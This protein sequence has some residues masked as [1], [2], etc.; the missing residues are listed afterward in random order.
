MTDAFTPQPIPTS[1]LVLGFLG[2]AMFSCRFLIQWIA[3][4]R[5]KTSI[6]PALFWWFS[7]AGGSFLLVYALLRRDVV[8]VVGQAG[9]L[10]VYLRNIF[11]LRRG[12]A[13]DPGAPRPGT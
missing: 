11:L 8:I 1:W 3:S 4:E 13:S 5:R 9:G 7:V 10:A 6:V 12:A 2:Q